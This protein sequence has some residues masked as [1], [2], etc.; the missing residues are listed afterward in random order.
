MLPIFSHV[1]K[2]SSLV[3]VTNAGVPIEVICLCV[4]SFVRRES[5]ALLVSFLLLRVSPVL[6]FMPYPF[7]ASSVLCIIRFVRRPF[8]ELYLL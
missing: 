7:R 6:Y 8:N 2:T 4:I 1:H 3:A 5:R